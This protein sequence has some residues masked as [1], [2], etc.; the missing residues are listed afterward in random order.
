VGLIVIRSQGDAAAVLAADGA[1]PL[2]SK[3]GDED[4]PKE[5]PKPKK[6]PDCDPVL[7]FDCKAKGAASEPKAASKVTLEKADILAVVKG[8]LATKV[9]GTIS[10]AS[11]TEV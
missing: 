11:L 2:L 5:E 6:N 9:P 7:D 3:A 10:P 8:A 4:A 1:S